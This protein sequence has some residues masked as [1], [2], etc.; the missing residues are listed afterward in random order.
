[1]AHHGHYYQ[2]KKEK[3][4]P[5]EPNVVGEEQLVQRRLKL[6]DRYKDDDIPELVAPGFLQKPEAVTETEMREMFK[7]RRRREVYEGGKKRDKDHPKEQ[8]R[9]PFYPIFGD[10]EGSYQMDLMFMKANTGT[11]NPILTM[12]HINRKVATVVHIHGKKSSRLVSQAVQQAV[13][14]MENT[15]HLPVRHIETDSGTEFKGE[16]AKWLAD[17]DIHLS[18]VN[19]NEGNKTRVGVIERFHRTLRRSLEKWRFRYDANDWRPMLKTFE[20]YYNYRWKHRGIGCTPM[21]MTPAKEARF[22]A[23]KQQKTTEI[24]AYYDHLEQTHRNRGQ[25][26]VRPET[27]MKKD[28]FEKTTNYYTREKYH[29]QLKPTGK[30]YIATDH[31]TGDVHRMKYQPY[32]LQ[33]VR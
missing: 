21:Q 6:T 15:Y 24:Q 23:Q 12:I 25:T 4:Q 33:W 13:H 5:G 27:T 8:E 30:A 17:H 11:K 18:M 2:W 7:E 31:A 19:P 28:R 32:Q 14:T 3:R 26:L 16:T 20:Y 22:V 1:V 29:A 9:A 10:R